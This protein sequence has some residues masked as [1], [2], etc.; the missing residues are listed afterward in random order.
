[1]L[2]VTFKS[3]TLKPEISV[4]DPKKFGGGDK[5]AIV[6]G[7]RFYA[8]DIDGTDYTY[9]FDN[10]WDLMSVM[11]LNDEDRVFF[12]SESGKIEEYPFSLYGFNA[13]IEAAKDA[14]PEM[15]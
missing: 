9:A 5:I 6:V 8:L 11:S 13:A 14:C 2:F 7:E 12:E 3:E 1:M 4:F 15:T 10:N